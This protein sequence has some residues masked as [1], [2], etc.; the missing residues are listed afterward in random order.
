MKKKFK[1]VGI[2]NEKYESINPNIISS[3]VET[4]KDAFGDTMPQEEVLRHLYPTNRLYLALNKKNKVVG[5][6][7][8]ILGDDYIEMS[9]VAVRKDMQG[10]GLYSALSLA[11]I[12]HGID[13]GKNNVKF[14]T[15]NPF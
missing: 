12:N 11:R 13:R 10:S 4:C 6:S 14:N 3:I 7:T 1:I 9:G 2:N 15:Q 8:L 5:F